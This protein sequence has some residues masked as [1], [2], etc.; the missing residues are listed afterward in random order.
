MYVY[1]DII[2]QLGSHQKLNK[3]L[4]SN[5]T[6]IH[7]SFIVNNNSGSSAY[8]TLLNNWSEPYPETTGYLIPVLLQ[9]EQHFPKLGFR[10]LAF[11]QINFFKNHLS[12]NG[13]IGL[14]DKVYFF[15]NTQI[16]LGLVAL[17]KEEQND[18]LYNIID[19]IYNW[20][21]SLIDNNGCVSDYNF[22]KAYTPAYYL[23]SVWALLLT[24]KTL[25]RDHD[26]TI[27]LLSK[28]LSYKT[29]NSAFENWS[30]D[31]DSFAFTHSIVYCYRGLW[32][33]ALI[34]DRKD[35]QEKAIQSIESLVKRIKIDPCG[36]AGRYNQQWKPD[37]SFICTAGNA[38]LALLLLSINKH[39][40]SEFFL[41]I[42][43]ELLRPLVQSRWMGHYN[44]LPSSLPIWG[45]YQ[46]FRFTN[47]TQKFYSEVLLKIL[48]PL[49]A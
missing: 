43:P 15:D 27:R 36:F 24:E 20:S 2:N 49:N 6:W 1:E 21:I 44:A 11:N 35:L 40:Q 17:Y 18:A 19:S 29:H 37:H 28:L 22:K 34:L 30:F 38:Q 13:G 39:T 33:S 48:T 8:S 9:A 45:K 32:E 16:L 31:G 5:L 3:I 10:D 14:Q 7:K 25:G 46:R 4:T 12:N 26:A 42:V 41:H 47:W 23:R